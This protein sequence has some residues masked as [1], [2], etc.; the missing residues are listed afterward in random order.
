MP[1]TIEKILSEIED[2]PNSSKAVLAEKII[3]ILDRDSDFEKEQLIEIKKRRSD[4][5]SGKVVP[6]EGEIALQKARS[7]INEL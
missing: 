4:L 3:E 6:V 1:V 7:V 5:L 2:M